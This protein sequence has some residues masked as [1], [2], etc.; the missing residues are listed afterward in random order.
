MHVNGQLMR[1]PGRDLEV[2]QARRAQIK[3]YKASRRGFFISSPCLGWMCGTG[4]EL[5]RFQNMGLG[6]VCA[7]YLPGLL[8]GST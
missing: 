8:P 7:L 2:P 5:C 3:E 4:S 1:C 6:L